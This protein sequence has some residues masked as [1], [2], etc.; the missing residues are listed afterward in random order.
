MKVK[1]CGDMETN[2]GKD[3]AQFK[4]IA[5]MGREGLGLNFWVEV[6]VWIGFCVFTQRNILNDL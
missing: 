2:G 1:V 4:W 3:Y 6:T 5:S